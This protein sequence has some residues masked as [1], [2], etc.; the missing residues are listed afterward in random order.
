MQA[1]SETLCVW[2]RR[3][4]ADAPETHFRASNTRDNIHMLQLQHLLEG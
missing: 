3:E 4:F 2:M 1:D